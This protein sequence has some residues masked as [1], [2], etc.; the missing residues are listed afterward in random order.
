MFEAFSTYRK[1]TFLAPSTEKF[2]LSSLVLQIEC[3]HTYFQG[4]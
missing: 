1:Q 4:N 2:F 3:V